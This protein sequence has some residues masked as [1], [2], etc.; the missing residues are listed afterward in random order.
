MHPGNEANQDDRQ[1]I[2]RPI[3]RAI[4]REGNKTTFT[5]VDRRAWPGGLL[6]HPSQEA[7]RMGHPIICGRAR[8]TR[9]Y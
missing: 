8:N 4:A 9:L 6:S 3:L 5:L 7:R 2:R 1:I